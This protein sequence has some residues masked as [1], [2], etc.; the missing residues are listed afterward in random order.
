M[1]TAALKYKPIAGEQY[2]YL[3]MAYRLCQANNG[4]VSI[5]KDTGIVGGQ[6]KYRGLAG[7]LETL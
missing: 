4:R 3:L 7:P 1:S 6:R 5:G 2:I